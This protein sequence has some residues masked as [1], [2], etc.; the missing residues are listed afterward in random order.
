MLKAG[1][2]VTLRNPVGRVNEAV[3]WIASSWLVLRLI[4][5]VFN[6][7]ETLSIRK[8]AQNS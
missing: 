8:N 2:P 1:L 4:D 6:R 7:A 5:A 3:A